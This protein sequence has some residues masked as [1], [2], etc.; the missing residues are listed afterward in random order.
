MTKRFTETAKWTDRWFRSLRPEFKLAWLYV[1][2][3]C[4]GAGV[5]E[6]DEVLANFQVGEEIEWDQFFETACDRIE[7]LPNGKMWV[8][9]FVEYQYGMLS[10]EC[11]AHRPVFASLEKNKLLERVSKGYPKG[12]DTLK[13]KE[14]EKDKDLSTEEGGG[15][16]EETMHPLLGDESFKAA[17]QRWFKH[18]LQKG[19]MLGSIEAE[20]QLMQLAGFGAEEATAMVEFSIGV[21]SKNLITNGDHKKSKPKATKF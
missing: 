6:V 4:D 1:L 12:M 5:I 19:K 3:N 9:K 14:K 10:R 18:R 13:E 11:K 7:A 8:I 16:G 2:D 15:V 20:T 17:W 21:G